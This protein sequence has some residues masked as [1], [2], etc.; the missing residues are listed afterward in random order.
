MNY[1]W[2][3]SVSY[4]IFYP[5]NLQYETTFKEGTKQLY[6]M[7]QPTSNSRMGERTSILTNHEKNMYQPLNCVKHEHVNNP[8]Q[9]AANP[10]Y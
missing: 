7:L 6:N 8:S 2:K 3:F 4:R 5:K 9:P 10:E 1:I